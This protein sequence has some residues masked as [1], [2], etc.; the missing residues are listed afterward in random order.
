MTIGTKSRIA[1][2]DPTAT[3]SEIT[4]SSADRLLSVT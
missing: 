1:D 4:Q 2:G 3:D